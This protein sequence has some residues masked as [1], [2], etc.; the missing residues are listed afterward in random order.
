MG[1][2]TSNAGLY[3]GTLDSPPPGLTGYVLG[4]APSVINGDKTTAISSVNGYNV[5]YESYG[6]DLGS[7]QTV[8]SFKI[9]DNNGSGTAFNAQIIV[10][11]GSDNN[12]WI[13]HETLTY[14]TEIQRT[15]GNPGIWTVTLN[16]PISARYWRIYIG[17]VFSVDATSASFTELEAYTHTIG[18]GSINS[19]AY[20]LAYS[21]AD[22][23]S[24]TVN[25]VTTQIATQE[26]REPKLKQTCDHVLSSGRYTL[27]TCPRCLGTG[28]YYDM[29]FNEVGLV[30]QIIAED[31]L[32]QELE[33]IT[34]TPIGDNIFH[35]QY[36]TLVARSHLTASTREIQE[37]VL[38][39]SIIDAVLHL[40][41]IQELEI[42]DGSPFS[43]RELIAR[44]EKVEILGYS[45][46][47]TAVQYVVHV[48][49]LSSTLAA[50]RGTIIL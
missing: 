15:G 31:K 12:N 35:D 23:N 27:T 19:N 45:T 3:N 22:P 38:K 42:S 11:Y 13:N 8:G 41:Q 36:G 7:V 17:G 2:I 9:Y 14:P 26:C 47:P 20:I 24:F 10:L 32:A 30:E 18:S 50:L 43:A 49:T 5:I 48:R 4:N 1:Q 28:Y 33:K 34:L 40:K 39:R 37:T 21:T 6:L 46:N 25:Q 16:V 29:K 44:I